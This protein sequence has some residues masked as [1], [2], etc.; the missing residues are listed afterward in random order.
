MTYCYTHKKNLF[1]KWFLVYSL[2]VSYMYTMCFDHLLSTFP[3]PSHSLQ[4][5]YF[6]FDT[7]S[8]Y[9]HV[10]LKFQPIVFN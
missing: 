7:F 9:F 5:P 3:I 4:N 8:S 6:F 10:F 2:T 1:L